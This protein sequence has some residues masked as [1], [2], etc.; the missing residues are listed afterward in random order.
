MAENI[1]VSVEGDFKVYYSEDLVEEIRLK[2]DIVDVIGEYVNIKKKGNS[3]TACCPFHPEKTPSFHVSRDKQMYHCFGCGVGGNVYTFV[4]EYENYTFPEAVKLLGERVGVDIPEEDM[5]PEARRKA[6]YRSTLFEMNKISAAYFHYILKTERGK[7]GYNYFHER[8][9]SNDTIKKFGLGYADMYSNDLYKYLRSKGYTDDV[10]K[11]SGLVYIDE[12]KGGNDRFWNRVMFP[13]IDANSKVI[14]FGGRV[15]G[16]GEPK[17]LNTNDTAVFDKSRNL[18]GLNFARKSKRHGLILCEGYMDVIAMHQ[19]GFD[20]A[21]A[22]LGTAFTI[23]HANL[24]KRYTDQVYLAY[25]SDGAGIKAASKVILMLREIGI[26]TRIINMRP[27]KDPDEFIKTLGVEAFEERIKNAVSS[28][29]FEVNL[30]SQNYNQ[31]DPESKTKFQHEV[32]K[33]LS[34]LDDPL[35]RT[36]YIEAV[37]KEYFIDVNGLTQLVNHYGTEGGYVPPSIFDDVGIKRVSRKE[38]KEELAKT[39]Q[40]LL[41]TMMVNMPDLFGKLQG[42]LS[43]KDFYEPLCNRVATLLFEQYENNKNIE[44]ASILNQF[45]EVDEQ[46]KVADIVQTTLEMEPDKDDNA[47]VVLD[48]V[49]KVKLGSIEHEMS[50]SNDMSIWQELIGEKAKVQKLHI[51]L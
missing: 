5:S 45:T 2:S 33:K 27:H 18:Y 11:N 17:Y 13:I 47:K 37:C 38:A 35:A 46:K 40:K 29:M 1:E 4:M 14:G 8:Q 39:P 16:E 31:N 24:V 25:D 21:V 9:L 23:G 42:V 49:K 36:N 12:V 6:D 26:T 10:L 43:P 34:I 41:L 15:M 30:I 22:S 20:N 48:I 7:K 44:A 3:Y 51:S 19:A 32:A 50:T 28:I